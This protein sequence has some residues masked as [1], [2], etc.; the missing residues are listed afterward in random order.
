MNGFRIR[1]MQSIFKVYFIHKSEANLDIQ[2]SYDKSACLLYLE[3]TRMPV[4]DFYRNENFMFD[5][6]P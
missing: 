6:G 5:S 4:K 1:S 2:I 3:A